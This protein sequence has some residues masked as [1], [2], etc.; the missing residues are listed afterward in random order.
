MFASVLGLTPLLF[1]WLTCLTPGIRV[2]S[3]PYLGLISN[4][5]EFV[6]YVQ[7][8]I[9]VLLRTPLK[10]SAGSTCFR[11]RMITTVTAAPVANTAPECDDPFQMR[12]VTVSVSLPSRAA[13]LVSGAVFLTRP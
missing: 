1:S 12:G 5:L 8:N 13:W 4:L 10:L 9:C 3:F 11:I 7:D 2:F 6:A